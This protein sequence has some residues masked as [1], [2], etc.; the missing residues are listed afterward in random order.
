MRCK[1]VRQKLITYLDGELKERQKLLM[2][3]HLSQCDKCREEV[4]S[5]LKISN[6]LKSWE[7]IKPSQCLEV[8]FWRR[9][10]SG[11]KRYPLFEPILRQLTPLALP[12]AITA[13]LIIGIFLGN[14]VLEKT[15]SSRAGSSWE[16]EYI[17]LAGLDS[18]QDFP[19]GSLSEAYFNS[20]S[21][22]Y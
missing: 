14:L 11:K 7:N 16:E 22:N 12:A 3:E 20:N 19:S 4:D 6:F 8:N 9:V 2:E 1:R 13:A 17:S 15:I 5:L 10:S 21:M 18:F